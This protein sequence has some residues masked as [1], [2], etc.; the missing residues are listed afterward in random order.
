M[1]KYPQCETGVFAHTFQEAGSDWQVISA[2]TCSKSAK[3]CCNKALPVCCGSTVL[4]SNTVPFLAVRLS[5]Q[6]AGGLPQARA[7]L[8]LRGL[9]VAEPVLQGRGR[10]VALC[11]LCW[12]QDLTSGHPGPPASSCVLVPDWCPPVSW[13]L[14]G[15]LRCLGT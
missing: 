12:P 1:I 9:A 11:C 7:R 14:A 5:R 3:V 6:A 2:G 13:Y 10:C 8:R 15:V 4:L